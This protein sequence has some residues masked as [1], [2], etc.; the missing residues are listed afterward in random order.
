MA[1]E[2]DRTD[3]DPTEA[4]AVGRVLVLMLVLV[5]G[6]KAADT[7]VGIMD[8][9]LPVSGDGGNDDDDDDVEV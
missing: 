1:D 6:V 5:L 9:E 8:G 4:D 3:T 7:K 2:G